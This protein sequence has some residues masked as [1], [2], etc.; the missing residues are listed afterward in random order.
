M[1]ELAED[2]RTLGSSRAGRIGASIAAWLE[3]DRTRWALWLPVALGAGV[4]AY[5]ALPVEPPGWIFPAAAGVAGVLAWALRRSAFAVS[6][7]IAVGGISAGAGIAQFRTWSVAAPVIEKRTFI[8]S[9]EGRVVRVERRTDGVR[10]TLDR[11]HFGSVSTPRV[12]ARIRVKHA[13]KQAALPRPGDRI[14]TRGVLLP[15]PAPATPGGYDFQRRA[16]FE[17]LGAVGYTVAPLAIT[18]RDT[19]SGFSIWLAGVRDA[20]SQRIRAALTAP[21]GEIATALLTGDRSGIARDDLEAMRKS[22]LAHLLAISGLHIGL[23]AG[24]IFFVVRLGLALSPSLAL[25]RPIKKW[26]AA[27]ALIGALGY[28]LIT[29]AT[30]PT[31]RAFLMIG[32]VLFAVLIDRTALTMRLVAWAAALILLIAPESLLGASFQLSFAA[33]VSLI[34]AYEGLSAWQASRRSGLERRTPAGRVLRYIGGIG[35]TTLI[36]GTATGLFAVYHFNRFAAY[37]L[38]A[39]L[40]SVPITA[41]WIMPWGLLALLLMPFGL[42]GLAL[43]PMGWGIDAVLGV[44]HGVA[45]W[46]GAVWLVPAMPPWGLGALTLGGLWLC[47]WRARW[48]WFG[49]AGPAIAMFSI[50]VTTPP[51]VLVTGDAR[52]MAVR[53]ADGR[54]ILSSTRVAGFTADGWLRRAGTDSAKPW[55]V[56]GVSAAGWLR[57]DA[58]SCLYTRHGRSVALVRDERALAEDCA[59]AEAVVSIEPIRIK[60]TGPQHVIGRFDLWRYGGHAIW[61]TGSGITARSV[62]EERGDR[63]WVLYRDRRKKVLK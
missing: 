20:A 1:A 9:L 35:L 8:G 41:L 34:A 25:R 2:K 59:R 19:E 16:W 55:P 7:A 38:A 49:L 33:V 40:V 28:M 30:V 43:V 4:A 5:F 21:A 53:G 48:R 60:C 51:D 57:C 18:G 6:I 22:G 36:A 29:G 10:L 3:A 13:I 56:T 37:G 45:G 27:A 42:E 17:K 12:P 63:P 46:T 61:M 58:A 52:L 15:P 23:A 50:A 54:Y 14:R 26:A 32:L 31:Q 47:I 44:A 24:F 39:N 62:A 11:L